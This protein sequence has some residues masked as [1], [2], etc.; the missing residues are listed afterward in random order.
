MLV[1][2]G[3][4]PLRDAP[5]PRFLND[6]AF[7]KLLQATRADPDPFGRPGRG[8]PGPHRPAQFTVDSVVQFGAAYW[9]HGPVGKLLGVAEAMGRAAADGYC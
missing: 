8:V 1:F 7:T 2:D 3:D 5:L 9:L 4:L 6:G